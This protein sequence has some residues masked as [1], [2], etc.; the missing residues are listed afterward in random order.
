MTQNDLKPSQWP[1]EF[2]DMLYAFALKRLSDPQTAE[3]LV[4]ECMIKGLESLDRFR[5]DAKIS[6]WLVGILKNL[7]FDYYRKQS[8]SIEVPQEDD[9]DEFFLSDGHWK[10]EGLEETVFHRAVQS[11]LHLCMENLEDKYRVPFLLKEKDELSGDDIADILGVKTN[12]VWIFLHRARL[13]LKTCVET[14]SSESEA[15]RILRGD[16]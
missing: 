3:D 12:S 11:S 5:G 2:G 15:M 14:K 6:T 10:L 7:I 1:Y 4:Q 13:K 9:L 16:V 8:R